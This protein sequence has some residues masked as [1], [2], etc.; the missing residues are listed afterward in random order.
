[1]TGLGWDNGLGRDDGS[2]LGRLVGAGRIDATARRVDDVPWV[3]RYTP[4]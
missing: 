1:M 4:P 2:G 3:R